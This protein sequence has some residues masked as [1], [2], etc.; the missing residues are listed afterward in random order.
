MRHDAAP[1]SF[2]RGYNA[3]SI[4]ANGFFDMRSALFAVI[5]D[6]DLDEQDKRRLR[7][8]LR[9]RPNVARKILDK[10]EAECKDEGIVSTNGTALVDWEGLKDFL[11]FLLPLLIELIGGLA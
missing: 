8:A 9:F 5:A 11:A 7:R 2:L 3:M 4:A 10:V 6:S 1:H